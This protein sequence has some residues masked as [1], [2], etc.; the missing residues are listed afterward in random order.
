MIVK[1]ACWFRKY[2]NCLISI[3]LSSESFI[4]VPGEFRRSA[5]E[6]DATS[7]LTDSATRGVDSAWSGSRVHAV[8]C[9]TNHGRILST[10]NGLHTQQLLWRIQV[11]NILLKKVIHFAFNIWYNRMLS[12]RICLL[13]CWWINTVS[14]FPN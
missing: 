10:D 9:D 6:P 3:G 13:H 4:F 5:G 11:R 2:Y 7:Y 12:F 14:W 1:L 8:L